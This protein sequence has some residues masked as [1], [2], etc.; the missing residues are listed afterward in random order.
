MATKTPISVNGRKTHRNPKRKESTSP[1]FILRSMIA[2]V[3]SFLSQ[4]NDVDF[5]RSEIHSLLLKVIVFFV[6]IPL[7]E[8]IPMAFTEYSSSFS[9]HRI[10]KCFGVQL[11]LD[12]SFN[13]SEMVNVV[14]LVEVPFD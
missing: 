5:P 2:V 9:L 14:G 12:L 11:R 10:S 4:M 13:A 1:P 6:P 8:T 7:V 3:A